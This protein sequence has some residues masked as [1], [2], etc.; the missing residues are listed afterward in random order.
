MPQDVI[1]PGA[2]PVTPEEALTELEYILRS[3]AF[4]RSER[5][6]RFLR[7]ICEMTLNGEASRI[8]EY[9]IGSEVFNKGA[10]YN[11]N[12]DSIVRRQAHALR[13][14]LQDYYSTAE[15]R[16]RPVRIELP[17]GRYV[18]T[19]RCAE[20]DA[21]NGGGK[22][23]VLG[24]AIAKA[25]SLPNE[26]P[27]P[28]QKAQP[29]RYVV[30]AIAAVVLVGVG[31]TVGILQHTPAPRAGA[32][33]IEAAAAEIWGAWL[34]SPRDVVICMSNP[35]AAVVKR[36]DRPPEENY[37]PPRFPVH[38]TE[39]PVIREAFKLPSG[40]RIYITPA[41]NMAK[42][43]EAVAGVYLGQFL[44]NAGKLAR[45]TQSRYLNWEA[46][47]R[48]N[49]ILLGNNESNQ[50]IDP[51]LKNYPFRLAHTTGREPRSIINT[52][53]SESEQKVYRIAYTDSA[54][55]PDEEYALVSMLAGLEADNQLL[56]IDGLN[57]QATQIATEFITAE[58]TL[59][60]LLTR[61]RSLDPGHTG[62]WRFQAVLKTR[63]YHDVPTRAV[64]VTARVIK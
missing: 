14:K 61:L 45:V 2:I 22:A 41:T 49:F 42:M 9:L 57:M 12:E 8:H 38:P 7:Y 43:G 3:P 32:P 17:V 16:G 31:I 29:G 50:W 6:Q 21:D 23:S 44:A 36:L 13:R 55:E 40:G 25:D 24:P 37:H 35:D 1:E 39:E 52:H 27:I 30:F 60:E 54:D 10:D 59:K 34:K 4:D 56:L 63:V 46:L 11:P 53:P 28:S 5:L 18:P 33:R 48:Q 20:P 62:V 26:A 64:L 47:R 19:F 58:A 15:G 51:L